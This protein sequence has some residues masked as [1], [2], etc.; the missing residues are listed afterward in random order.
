VAATALDDD[1]TEAARRVVDDVDVD[2]FEGVGVVDDVD[3][4]DFEGV[5]V[6]DVVEATGVVDVAVFELTVEV[7]EETDVV[8][9]VVEGTVEVRVVEEVV[10]LVGAA[11]VGT[12]VEDA[13]AGFGAGCFAAL[14]AAA[15]PSP[16][17]LQHQRCLSPSQRPRQ[18]A[19]PMRQSKGGL[20][21]SSA[22]SRSAGQ[23]RPSSAQH[24]AL[25]SSD[26]R[27]SH[28]VRLSRQLKF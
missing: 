15:Q 4:D 1:V 14:V 19:T 9:L 25:F 23:P 11:V 2:D 27:S 8:V 7:N 17:W 10:V 18:S 5:G 13:G 12:D 28:S 16:R 26:Q 22:T 24:H 6:V 20:P 21:A 3:V